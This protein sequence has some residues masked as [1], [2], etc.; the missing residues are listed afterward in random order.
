MTDHYLIIWCEIS[1]LTC[2]LVCMQPNY[3]KN[4]YIY[5]CEHIFIYI[6]GTS[7]SYHNQSLL[8]SC[9][10]LHPQ[11]NIS[12][13]INQYSFNQFRINVWHKD[14]RI[15]AAG[16]TEWEFT[17]YI[18]AFNKWDFGLVINIKTLVWIL[19]CWQE[20]WQETGHQEG[21][22]LRPL[23]LSFYDGKW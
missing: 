23:P 22:A 15:A 1:V 12:A 14:W 11:H 7:S 10:V 3:V 16:V 18:G 4:I 17:N 9:R 13:E 21:F 5:V 6:R 2:C 19:S 20:A 8:P